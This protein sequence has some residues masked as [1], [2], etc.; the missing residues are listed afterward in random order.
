M[1][2]FTLSPSV[3]EWAA[4][5]VGCTL[6]EL[7]SK[8]SKSQIRTEQIIGG[9]LTPPQVRKFAD[10]TRVPVGYLFLK[11]PPAPRRL[12]VADF[13]SLPDSLP[14]SRDFYETFDD[15]TYKQDW[16]E[17]YLESI[18]A[19]PLPFIGSYSR[20][21]PTIADAAA[22]ITA[23]VGLSLHEAK[24]LPSA[25][26]YFSY[27]AAKCE[28]IGILVF[29][30]GVVGNNTHRPLSVAEFRGFALVNR[31]APAVFINGAD[32][33]AAWIF[34]LAHE[35]THLWLG[36]S[37]VSDTST[38]A[39]NKNERYCNAVAA[40]I[41]VPDRVFSSRWRELSGEPID[42]RFEILSRELK[43]SRLVIER[44]ALEQGITDSDSFEQTYRNFVEKKKTRGGG[45]NYYSSLATRNSKKLTHR[46]VTLAMS[47]DITLSEAGKLLNTNPGNIARLNQKYET[48]SI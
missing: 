12:P 7:A 34:T 44:K 20:K 19:E 40:E 14:L 29:K 4:S 11:E 2:T 43:V 9:K 8:V 18:G 27:L 15:I 32:A 6:G 25:D 45:G 24:T 47:G 30:N 35:V 13:R 26:A 5:Q 33:P 21:R 31:L 39:Q 41:L 16:Y 46:V 38:V 1:E 17:S 42:I 48:L 10:V 36:V 3:L 23:T 37:G 28:Q 22:E